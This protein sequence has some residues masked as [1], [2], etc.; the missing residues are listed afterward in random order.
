MTPGTER[1]D[2]P[3]GPD[4]FDGLDPS[5][6]LATPGTDRPATTPAAASVQPA[7]PASA[8]DLQAI[9]GR[10]DFQQAVRDTLARAADAGSPEIVMVDASYEAW[11]LGE[12]SVA[13]TLARWA[14]SRR[15]LTLIGGSF[16]ALLQ[17][18]P[19]FLAWRRTWSHIVSFRTPDDLDPEQVPTWLQVPGL[20]VVRIHDPL[21]HR[22]IVSGRAIDQVEARE[23][24]DA[25]SQRSTETFPA[26]TLGL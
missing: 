25:L 5:E 24:V 7:V 9:D 14:G 4:G 17:R 6:D 16:D 2:G 19:R 8:L 20:A 1:P 23:L 12:L 10:R 18:A 26:T 11:P 15:R 22:G 3:D 21:H 13:E